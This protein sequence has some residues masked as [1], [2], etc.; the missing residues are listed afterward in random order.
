[1]KVFIAYKHSGEEE[2]ILREVLEQISA[3]FE[4]SGMETFI[5][6]RD[7]QKWED[8][9]TWT[10]KEIISQ[11]LARQRECELIFAYVNSPENSEGL[12]IEIGYAKAMNKRII[13]AINKRFDPECHRYLRGLSDVVITF[14]DV[15]DL[16][17]KIKKQ[18]FKT[19]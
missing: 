18:N 12:S 13:L 15:N 3:A 7:V 8:A 4:D 11:A 5:F 9:T 1:M 2:S 6:R 19:L 17:E 14:D 10:G 16:C